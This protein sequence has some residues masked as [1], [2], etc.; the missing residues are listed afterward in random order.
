MSETTNLV[1]G[2]DEL[3]VKSLKTG[4][5]SI[6]GKNSPEHYS[7]RVKHINEVKNTFFSYLSAFFQKFKNSKP[8]FTLIS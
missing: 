7:P 5:G 4:T 2:S 6:W 8:N 1:G 3:T